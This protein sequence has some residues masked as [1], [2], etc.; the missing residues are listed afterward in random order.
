[1]THHRA[2]AWVG[3]VFLLSCGRDGALIERGP[4]TDAA[5]D[6]AGAGGASGSGAT[7][8]GGMGT[9]QGGMGPA[10]GGSDACDPRA[11]VLAAANLAVCARR[12]DGKVLCWGDNEGNTL[13][14]SAFRPLSRPIVLPGLEGVL[15]V[16]GGG[17][18]FCASFID[19]KK[20]PRCWGSITF[21][22]GKRQFI[23]HTTE[24][25]AELQADGLTLGAG[26]CVTKGRKL[27]CWGGPWPVPKVLATEVYDALWDSDRTVL[28]SG[29]E[30]G[31]TMWKRYGANGA[32]NVPELPDNVD[33]VRANAPVWGYTTAQDQIALTDATARLPQVV[34]SLGIDN[35]I[36]ALSTLGR[37][38][39]AQKKGGAVSCWNTTGAAPTVVPGVQAGGYLVV[40]WNGCVLQND[41]RIL[42]W[43]GP[44]WEH[45]GDDAVINIPPLVPLAAPK[46]VNLCP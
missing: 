29:P 7:V 46:F 23:E 14:A 11:Y 42:C 34:E 32:T 45:N 30:N 38:G 22:D 3:A 27:T 10:Q 2:F 28:A 31:T 1:M 36:F 40:G 43:D 16:D 4:Q 12:V 21:A 37:G 9:V 20:T 41:W 17:G 26:I 19:G 18:L 24:L 13:G 6:A 25:P 35:T 8:Q 15:K 5:A 44:D 33:F 39:C